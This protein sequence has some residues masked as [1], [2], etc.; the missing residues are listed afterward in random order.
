MIVKEME[1][2]GAIQLVKELESAS[3]L[4]RPESSSEDLSIVRFNSVCL[5]PGSGR[6]VESESRAWAMCTVIGAY[7][8]S[9]LQNVFKSYTYF[10]FVC[11]HILSGHRTACEVRSTTL[12]S[13]GLVASAI[14][15]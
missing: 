12:R 3:N 2:G 6:E 15:S 9:L 14:T 11:V 10:V 5:H 1:K 8:V 13:A 7:T 4:I